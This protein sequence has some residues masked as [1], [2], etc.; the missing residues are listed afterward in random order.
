MPHSSPRVELPYLQPS[1]AQKD[2]THNEALQRL[3]AVTQLGLQGF[4]DTAPP[5]LPTPGDIHG[6]GSS[7]TGAWAGHGHELAYWSGDQWLFLTPR[8]GWRAWG[9]GEQELRVWRD[10]QWQAIFDHLDNMERLGVNATADA[11]NRLAVASD[12]SLLSHDGSG[13]QL[14]VNKAA[15]GDTASLV[16]QSNWTGHAE[17]GL[18]GT[19]DWSI[20]VS[21]DGVSWVDALGFDNGTGIA[22]GAAVQQS[23]TDTT[24]GRLARADYAYGRGNLLGAVS[25]AGGTPT[26]AVIERGSNANGEYVRFADGTQICVSPDFGG[27]DITT[28]T[29]SLYRSADFEWSFPATFGGGVETIAGSVTSMA[30]SNTHWG[31]FRI[32]GASIA[33]ITVFGPA[34]ITGRTV[35]AMA[36]GRWF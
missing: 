6:L 8:D 33:R 28:L 2:V 27:V 30:N 12:A 16:F 13:H 18:A 9:V 19:N 34:S 4:A 26:G 22:S 1:Q 10:G 15:P 5:E 36:A 23:E 35:R 31:S 24:V 7:P 20:K 25:E 29:G 17:M 32:T 14:K 11:T 3:D 21:P